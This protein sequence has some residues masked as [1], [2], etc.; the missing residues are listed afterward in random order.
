MVIFTASFPI[1]AECVTITI[2]FILT[3]KSRNIATNNKR[4]Y[5]PT[6]VSMA[7]GRNVEKCEKSTDFSSFDVPLAKRIQEHQ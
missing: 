7:T 3:N 6:T 5:N 2:V 4:M 1:E